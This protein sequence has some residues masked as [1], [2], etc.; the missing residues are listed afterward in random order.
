MKPLV[1]LI[2]LAALSVGNA[3]AQAGE[4]KEAKSKHHQYDEKGERH[5]K[6]RLLPRGHQYHDRNHHGQGREHEHYGKSHGRSKGR[7]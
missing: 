1:M 4:K 7:G 3:Q 5:R 6:F 2:M